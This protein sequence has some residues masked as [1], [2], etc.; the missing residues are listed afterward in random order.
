MPPVKMLGEVVN[1]FSCCIFTWKALTTMLP[2]FLLAGAIA[3]FVS[4]AS[5][6]KYLGPRA[7]KPLAYGT[8]ALSGML[9][10]L[11]SC[12]VVP[13][14]AS[15]Y[16]C[17][18]GL[19]PAMTFLYAGPAINVL[20]LIW[21]IR[22][23]G[24]PLGIWRAVAVP[25]LA[26]GIGLLMAALFARQERA[27]KDEDLYYGDELGKEAGPLIA[28]IGLLLGSVV[29]GGWDNLPLGIRL[30]LGGGVLAG[31][32]GVLRWG[33]TPAEVRNWLRH[34]WKLV[35]L[36]LPI[37][38]PAVLVIGL[39]SRYIPLHWVYALV[40]HNTLPSIFGATVFG[41]LMYFPILTEVPFVK[42]FLQLG[43][44]V[45]PG[46]ALLLTGPGLSLPGMIIVRQV[47]GTRKLLAYVG[48][49]ILGVTLT[50]WLFSVWMGDYL[51]PCTLPELK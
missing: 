11:C 20:S 17:G 29:L 31:L 26:L 48:L 28:L 23:I 4:S 37:L 5:V 2:A 33:F 27:R 46:L 18:A 36:V 44:G 40:G 42:M 51:C 25:V 30:V 16:M 35:K 12:N 43:M 22:V 7:K 38:L 9:L 50:A 3:A 32:V 21:V 24:W 14:F 13:L 6:V 41:A 45:G 47:L 8:A 19:G 39:L 1:V 49:M 15:V 34:T 10:S